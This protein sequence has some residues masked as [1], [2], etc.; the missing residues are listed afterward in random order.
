MG[1]KNANGE[2]QLLGR[3]VRFDAAGRSGLLP[4]SWAALVVPPPASAHVAASLAPMDLLA[5]GDNDGATAR[6]QEGGVERL[7]K[8]K[9]VQL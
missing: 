9:G 3:A 7:P 2:S 4:H 8:P 5:T 6:E 1:S